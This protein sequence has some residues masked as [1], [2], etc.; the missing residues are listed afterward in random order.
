MKWLNGVNKIYEA[1]KVYLHGLIYND[2]I[3]RINKNNN[4]E[5]EILDDYELIKI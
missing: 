5:I 4:I 2:E 3:S 1:Y